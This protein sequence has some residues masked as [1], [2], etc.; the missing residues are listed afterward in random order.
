[1]APAAST[2]DV[3]ERRTAHGAL[4]ITSDH[5][6][7]AGTSALSEPRSTLEYPYRVLKVPLERRYMDG[8]CACLRA[9]GPMP[10]IPLRCQ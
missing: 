4:A 1:M 6:V 10:R 8:G 3:C 9:D 7:P 2:T 5:V